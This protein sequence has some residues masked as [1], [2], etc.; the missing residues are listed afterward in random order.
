MSKLFFLA[1]HT[2]TKIKSKIKIKSISD[3]LALYFRADSEDFG[4]N[5]CILNI[6][7]SIE[8]QAHIWKF[9]AF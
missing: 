9:S 4:K 6:F 8:S 5:V 7:W 2:K 3:F 1:K